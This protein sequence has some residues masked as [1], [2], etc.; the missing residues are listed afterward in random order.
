MTARRTLARP[1]DQRAVGS[2]PTGGCKS[3]DAFNL[4]E[5][6]LEGGIETLKRGASRK[7]NRKYTTSLFNRSYLKETYKEEP[8]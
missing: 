8:S 3:E 6:I 5:K 1:S 4:K 7:K 2:L